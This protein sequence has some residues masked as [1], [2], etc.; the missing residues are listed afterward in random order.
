LNYFYKQKKKQTYLFKKRKVL[1]IMNY[2]FKQ[3]V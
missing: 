3:V 2:K 1:L